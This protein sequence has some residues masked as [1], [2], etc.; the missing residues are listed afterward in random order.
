MSASTGDSIRVRDVVALWAAAFLASAVIGNHGV[1][2][3]DAGDYVRLAID[4][5]QS[6]MLLGRPLFLA[7]SH[8]ILA[9]GV[10]PA[11]AEPVLRWFWS[12]VSAIAA[13][14]L[15]VLAARLGLARPASL[16]AG[17]ALALSPSFAHTSHQVLTDGPSLALA[18]CALVAATASRPSLSGALLGVAIL[19]RE[20]AAVHVV[21]VAILLGRR[22]VPAPGG[23]CSHRRNLVG[24]SASGV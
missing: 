12:A 14:A 6:G 21:A 3:W 7:I 4:G 2:Y 18:I 5:G 23:R 15:A 17:A 9:A 16:A 11:W 20:T 1:G 22:A 8:L 10:D 24:L 13:P 19:T